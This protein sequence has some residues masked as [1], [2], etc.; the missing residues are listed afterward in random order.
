MNGWDLTSTG[1]YFGKDYTLRAGWAKR[2]IYV[3][4]PSEAYYPSISVDENG[5]QL[6]GA[7]SYSITFPANNLPPAKYFW[8]LTMYHNDTKLMVDN[9]MKRY[10]IGDR[11]KGLT[12]NNDGSLTLYFSNKEPKEGK[13]NWLPSPEGDFYMLMRLYGPSKKVLDNQWTP[14]AIHKLEK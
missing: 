11:T 14:P 6:N 7:N 4:S 5:V 13:S 2:A 8:S 3:N 9:D 10:S 1:E 12:Y